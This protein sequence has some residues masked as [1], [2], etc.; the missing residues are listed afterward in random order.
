MRNK[1]LRKD[2]GA[3]ADIVAHTYNYNIVVRQ[4]DYIMWSDKR[5]I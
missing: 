2:G 1:K 4:K 3:P 5:A